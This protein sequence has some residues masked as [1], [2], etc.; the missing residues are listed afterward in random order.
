VV[1]LSAGIAQ[2]LINLAWGAYLMI[3]LRRFHITN[4]ITSGLM[5]PSGLSA[6]YIAAPV[7][8]GAE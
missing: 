2:F 1:R 3:S 8:A 5:R 6:H 4:E 7:R